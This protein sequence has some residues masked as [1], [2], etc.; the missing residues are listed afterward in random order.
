MFLANTPHQANQCPD[1]LAHGYSQV[2]EFNLQTQVNDK[3]NKRGPSLKLREIYMNSWV[4]GFL[5]WKFKQLPFL[6]F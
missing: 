3:R 2:S 6:Y 1:Q 5:Q 4:K